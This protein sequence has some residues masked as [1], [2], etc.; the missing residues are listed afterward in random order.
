MAIVGCGLVETGLACIKT[1]GVIVVLYGI[2]VAS[3]TAGGFAAD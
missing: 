1:A 2:P 3:A